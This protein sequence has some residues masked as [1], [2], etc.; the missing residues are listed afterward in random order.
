MHLN[1]VALLL[2]VAACGGPLPQQRAAAEKQGQARLQ[3]L[4]TA[5]LENG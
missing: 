4:E 2:L 3:Q 1:R 5:G